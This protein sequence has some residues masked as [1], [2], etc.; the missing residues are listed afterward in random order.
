[1]LR[2]ALESSEREASGLQH[3]SPL[4]GTKAYGLPAGLRERL[5][6]VARRNS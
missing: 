1:M 3:V 6:G 5:P 2:H 4:H